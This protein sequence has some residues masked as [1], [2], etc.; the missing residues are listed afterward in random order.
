MFS[1]LFGHGSAKDLGMLHKQTK[2][3]DV[4]PGVS[5]L[6]DLQIRELVTSYVKGENYFCWFFS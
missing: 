6:T 1:Q 3:L 4:V 5:T 2:D